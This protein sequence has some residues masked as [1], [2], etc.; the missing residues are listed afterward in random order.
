MADLLE[1]IW[2]KI[3]LALLEHR[4]ATYFEQRV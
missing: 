3:D 2:I 4:K 1:K